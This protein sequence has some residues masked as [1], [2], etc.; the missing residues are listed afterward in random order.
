[1]KKSKLAVSVLMFGLVAPALAA[2]P[3]CERKEAEIKTQIQ[4]ATQNDNTHR[5]RG[6]EKALSQVQTH[7]SDAG[8][9]KD[10]KEDIADQ[11]ED[12]DKMLAKIQEKK[13][14]GRYD[15]VEKLEDK[16]AR[17]REDLKT[18]QQELKE[19]EA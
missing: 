4:H 15:K 5:V 19:L 1:M 3:A 11:Q 2:S 14:E 7:C 10:K 9:I 6:L 17:E 13:S 18:L 16:L 8:L 12:I